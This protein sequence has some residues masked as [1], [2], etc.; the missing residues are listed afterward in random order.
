MNFL[1]DTHVLIWYL[2]GSKRLPDK[3]LKELDDADNHVTVSIVSL[4]ELA[5]KISLK[6]METKI[7][8][9]EIQAD[10][11]KRDFIPL[12]ISFGHLNA[13][14]SLEFYHGDPFDRLLIAQAIVEN[15]TMMSAD[16]QFTAYP[17]NVIW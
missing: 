7:T 11:L 10:I 14:S 15:L 6:K 2:D 5:I 16:K 12:P 1:I 8:L 13:L 4:W 17:I 9:E 3:I